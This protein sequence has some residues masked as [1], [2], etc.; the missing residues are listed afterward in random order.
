MAVPKK[1]TSKSKKGQRRSHH[2]LSQPILSLCPKCK[3]PI[4]SHTA[5]KVCGEYR[6]MQVI[7]VEKREK[8]KERKFDKEKEQQAPY[9]TK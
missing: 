3:S 8:R 6:G 7:D 4:K 5:C 2:A 9:E 1:K